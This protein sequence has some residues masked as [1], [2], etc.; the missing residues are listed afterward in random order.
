MPSAGE[1]LANPQYTGSGIYVVACYPSL[2]CLYVGISDCVYDRLRQHLD[3]NEPLAQFIGANIAD[4]CAFRL[5]VL[6]PPTD[7]SREWM[8]Q[9]ERLLVQAL[10]PVFNEQHLG[11]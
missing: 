2:G 10:R 7:S 11:Q 8:T 5:D 4:A 6:T 3:S 1:Y 9:A